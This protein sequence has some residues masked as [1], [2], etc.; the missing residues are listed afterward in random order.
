M[1]MGNLELKN[2]K[3]NE[4]LNS[5][6]GLLESTINSV[7]ERYPRVKEL[8]GSLASD[9]KILKKKILDIK[10]GNSIEKGKVVEVKYSKK[11][12]SPYIIGDHGVEEK[13]TIGQ[14]V[15]GMEWGSEFY[16]SFDSFK[17][18]S[19]A[20]LYYKYIA[21]YIEKETTNTLNKHI[22]V[23][24][25]KV[26]NPERAKAYNGVL[27]GREVSID[28]MSYGVKAE[29]LVE[30]YLSRIS[31]DNPDLKF[32]LIR[33]NAYEDVSL[34]VDFIVKIHKV[35]KGVKVE[36]TDTFRKIQFTTNKSPIELAVK[37]YRAQ[38]FGV[39]LVQMPELEIGE[40]FKAWKRNKK[41]KTKWPDSYLPEETQAE[42]KK[43]ILG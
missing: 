32:E 33:T 28:D 29:R 7:L 37:K 20:D 35:E 14:V 22:A 13:I 15:A 4:T 30:A 41:D 34:T 2:A 31:L 9:I 25:T 21:K 1:G 40:V 10:K 5:F 16:L 18:A 17:D 39:V 24:E 8:G 3:L 38:R 6:E 27:K 11:L 36:S 23:N 19:K 43:A 12:Q 26:K 42:I